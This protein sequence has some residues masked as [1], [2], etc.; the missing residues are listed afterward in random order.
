[1][2]IRI[3]HIF[4]CMALAIGLAAC[5]KASD[6]SN[7]NTGEEAIQHD[8]LLM[9]VPNNCTLNI[10]FALNEH[11]ITS[12]Q[13]WS[14]C[15]GS[16]QDGIF[17]LVAKAGRKGSSGVASWLHNHATNATCTDD[18]NCVWPAD[19]NF[20]FSGTI[21]I[22]G[23]SYQVTIG[24]GSTFGKNNWWIGGPGWTIHEGV[25]YNVRTPD[26]KYYFEP[27]ENSSDQIWI[28]TEY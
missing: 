12:G 13:P 24:Q 1:M 2:K 27:E 8:N 26:Q 5:K 11:S 15:S 3:L 7:T 14:G 21:T 22:N 19:L 20:A 25:T 6:D 23:D 28:K 16:M 17:N 18:C 9:L 10:T 4:L